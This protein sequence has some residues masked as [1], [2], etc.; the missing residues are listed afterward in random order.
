MEA[1]SYVGVYADVGVA[2]EVLDDDEVDALFQEQGGGRVLEVVKADT[3]K[4]CPAEERPKRR[5]RLVGSKELTVEVVKTSPLSVQ[6]D[7]ATWRSSCWRSRWL[8]SEWMHS[9]GSAVRRS[10]ARVLVRRVAR[11]LV[12]V[13]WRER[14]MLAV[15]PSRSRSSQRRPRG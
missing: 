9:E 12:R 2:E 10:E 3:T 4:P 6:P 1:E 8:L 11:P 13:R 7:P 14:W 15:P 5:V